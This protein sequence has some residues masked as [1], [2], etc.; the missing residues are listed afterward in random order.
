[1][2]FNDGNTNITISL[3]REQCQLLSDYQNSYENLFNK[4]LSFEDLIKVSLFFSLNLNNQ[5]LKV[6]KSYE[7]AHY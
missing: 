6:L 4:K 3:T 1:M 2:T 5:K 7:V